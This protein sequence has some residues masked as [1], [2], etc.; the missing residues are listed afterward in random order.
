MSPRKLR[1]GGLLLA[2]AGLTLALAG[3]GDVSL[4]A[5]LKGD[6]PG[7]LRFSPTT[8]LVPENTDFAFSVLGG[9]TPYTVGIGATLASREGA[10]WV[11]QGQ[12]IAGQ[13]E[14]FTIQA[15]DLLGNTATAEVTV[16]AVSSPL[17]LDV[18]EVTLLVGGSWTF[19]ASGG[20]GPYS[21]SVDEVPVD[22]AP[23]PDD[24]YTYTPGAEGA[25]TVTVSDSIGL[26]QS[27]TVTVKPNDPGLPLEITP[28]SVTVALSGTATFMALGGTGDYTFEVVPGGAGGKLTDPKANPATYTAPAAGTGS[29]TVS[30]SDGAS[31]VTATVAVIDPTGSPLS[32]SP[33]NPTVSAVGDRIQFRAIGGTPNPAEP[34]Y[35][36]S[37][38]K[39]GTG[40]ID[41]VTGSYVQLKEGHVVV[42]VRDGAGASANTLVKFL[43]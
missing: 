29:D 27:A 26:S 42:T 6:S 19:H 13:S 25:F 23:A 20:A 18:T 9:I 24:A 16:Y 7:D 41:P 11:F 5:A 14:L 22:P 4:L 8:A 31:A 38:N 33:Q 43:K 28:L 35:T 3:C 17:A 2:A 37:T 39:P 40:L 34:Y 12:D 15:T 10:T 1:I 30:L 21:W 36:F 32:L